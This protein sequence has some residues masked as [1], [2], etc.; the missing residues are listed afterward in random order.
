MNPTEIAEP[1]EHR[2]VARECAASFG[3]MLEGYCTYYKLTREEALARVGENTEEY[4]QQILQHP[5]DEIYWHEIEHVGKLN[6]QKALEL[7]SE[8]KNQALNEL[9]SGHRSAKVLHPVANSPW[10]RAQYLALRYELAEEW[11]PRNGIERQLIDTMALA[12]SGYFEW[13]ETLVSRTSLES[14]GR[15]KLGEEPPWTPPRISDAEAVEQAAAMMDRFNKIFLRS[16]RALRDLRRYNRPV[17]VQNAGQVNVGEKQI[18]VSGTVLDTTKAK[19][20]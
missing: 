2:T 3:R 16:L 15:K 10:K 20:T 11:Q 6:P 17:I 14:V 1:A 18:N 7:W 19:T 12:Q 8:I 5:V 4:A 13:L 9:R